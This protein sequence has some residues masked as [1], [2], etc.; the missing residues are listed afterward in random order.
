MSSHF[1]FFNVRLVLLG[2]VQTRGLSMDVFL[3]NTLLLA[4][5]PW[6]FFWALT[7]DFIHAMP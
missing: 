6:V 7:N 4:Y 3:S 1:F 5:C 2:G